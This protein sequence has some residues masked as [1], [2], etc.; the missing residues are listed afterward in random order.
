MQDI[1]EKCDRELNAIQLID[2]LIGVSGQLAWT[3]SAIAG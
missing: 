1:L 2:L 3:P